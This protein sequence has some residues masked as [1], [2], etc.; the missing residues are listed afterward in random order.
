MNALFS[1]LIYNIFNERDGIK[2]TSFRILHENAY[3]TI[4]LKFKGTE[5]FSSQAMTLMMVT[6]TRLHH[7]G[8]KLEGKLSKNYCDT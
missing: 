3:S 8:A 7:I 2:K 5:E 4:L 6:T 1:I